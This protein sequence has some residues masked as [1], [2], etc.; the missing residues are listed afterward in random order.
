MQLFN[1]I[2]HY[3]VVVSVTVPSTHTEVTQRAG[4]YNL[5]TSTI[6]TAPFLSY[7]FGYILEFFEE[8]E[9]SISNVIFEHDLGRNDSGIILILEIHP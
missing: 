2:L 5:E 9:R 8:V 7:F 6:E 4:K 1:L 3:S